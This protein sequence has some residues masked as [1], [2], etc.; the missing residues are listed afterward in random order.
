MATVDPV[1]IFTINIY[2]NDGTLIKSY[3]D[4]SS[5]TLIFDLSQMHSD[6]SDM[7]YVNVVGIS[8]N[9]GS[10]VA[11]YYFEDTTSIEIT[12]KNSNFYIVESHTWSDVVDRCVSSYKAASGVSSLQ[13]GQVAASISKLGLLENNV[14]ISD[15]DPIASDGKD[16][17]LWIVV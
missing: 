6:L 17:D 2:T 13:L 15:T 11:D 9:E 14:Y 3:S 7:G 5:T 4:S 12:S 1:A 8:K 10:L 16:G